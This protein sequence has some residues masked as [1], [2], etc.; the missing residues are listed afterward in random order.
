MS[1]SNDWEEESVCNLL[2]NLAAMEVEPQCNDELV[3]PHD[4]EGSF[5]VKS[6]CNALQDRSR[7][8]DFPSLAIWK[9]KAPQKACFFAWAAAREKVQQRAFLK[10][11]ISTGLV[12]VPCA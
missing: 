12:G 5:N 10:E 2:A 8:S 7:Y 11:E 3:L 4:I 1:L 6:F 9:S